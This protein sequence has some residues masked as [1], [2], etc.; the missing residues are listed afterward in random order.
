MWFGVYTAYLGTWIL[1]ASLQTYKQYLRWGLEFLYVDRTYLI[2]PTC[3]YSGPQGRTFGIPMR[4]FSTNNIPS[5]CRPGPPTVPVFHAGHMVIPCLYAEFI[6]G[7]LSGRSLC[8]SHHG[9]L[10]W[11]PN[12]ESLSIYIYIYEMICYDKT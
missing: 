11:T 9:L 2:G 8:N 1:R 5:T 12:L 10:A 3:G 7:Q 6:Q 4:P